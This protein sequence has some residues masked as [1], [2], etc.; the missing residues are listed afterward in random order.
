M[1]AENH[2]VSSYGCLFTSVIAHRVNI[3][4]LESTEEESVPDIRDTKL[5]FSSCIGNK[6]CSCYF[7]SRRRSDSR[8]SGPILCPNP[9]PL[10]TG[11]RFHHRVLYENLR[12]NHGGYRSRSI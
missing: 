11:P 4:L 6:S 12:I 8:R 5:A 7:A 2:S 1:K 3:P 10:Q 9:H